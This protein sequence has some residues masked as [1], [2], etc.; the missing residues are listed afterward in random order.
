MI[1]VADGVADAVRQGAPVVALETTVITHGLPHPEGVDTALEMEATV[2]SEGATPA[3]IGVLDGRL[4]VGLAEAELRRLATSPD[5]VKLNLSN[6][7]ARI[8]ASGVGSLTVAATMFAAHGASIRVFATGGIGGVH[9]D[10]GE[11]GDVSADLVALSRYPVAVVCSGAKAVLD[12][13]KTR[14]ALETLG[15]PV[16]GLGTDELPAFYR[17]R[18]GVPVDARFD[19]VEAI[20]RAIATHFDLGLGTGVMVANPIP[21]ADELPEDVYA[22]ALDEALRNTHASGR[23]ATPALLEAMRVASGGLSVRANRALLINNARVAAQLA[24]ALARGG[25]LPAR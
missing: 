16:Y 10:A 8:A 4:V 14:E 21:E 7:A 24:G 15:V 11:T 9:R 2:R 25:E 3:T 13:P 23:D 18:S 20:A 17:R 6:M 12:L 22:R 5:V 1:A 19:S